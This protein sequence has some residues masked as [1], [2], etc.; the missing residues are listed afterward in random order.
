MSVFSA[1]I[2]C[3][4]AS[5]HAGSISNLPW[6]WDTV[7]LW[8][9]F[10]TSNTSLLDDYQA[11]F[12]A[13]H[14]D[15]ISLEKCLGQPQKTGIPTED[16]FYKIASSIRKYASTQ[17]TK[18]LFYFNIPLCLC[19]CYAITDSFCKNESM[20]FKDD[21]GNVIYANG[22]KN[23]PYFDHSQQSVR[24]WWVNA[25][26]SVMTTAKSKG[27]V[28]NG[29]FGDGVYRYWNPAQNVS[30]KR[31][32]EYNAGI[33]S[34]LDLTRASFA[35]IN[36]DDLFVIGNGLST[37]PDYIN[38]DNNL[39]AMAHCDGMLAEHF[40]AFEEVINSENGK[41]NVTDLLF[42][43]NV[44]ESMQKNVY[45][46]NKTLLIKAWIG[47][48]TGPINGFGPS[49]PSTYNAKTPTT[50]VQVQNASSSLILFP[51]S[52]YLC[53]IYNEYVYFNYAWWYD[54]QQ[55]YVPCP[56]DPTSCDCP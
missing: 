1:A 54:I 55:G 34:L 42:W 13:T 19:D 32:N 28:V 29:I 44:S 30:A 21:N 6:S 25:V 52:V 36:N 27:I 2:V 49:W 12:I 51:L 45:G 3:L 10:G 4:L 31:N 47:P 46:A 43:Y 16:S 38:P 5:A 18:I 24:E 33:L 56:D 11:K 15:I 17:E 26:S 20:M 14:Y 53:G 9:D 40:G 37:Y 35:Q 48:E 50:H 22:D 7:P 23:R 39:E 8:A 41:I